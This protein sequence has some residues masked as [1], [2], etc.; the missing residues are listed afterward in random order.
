MT[1]RFWILLK[2]SI[3]FLWR[4]LAELGSFCQKHLAESDGI[5]QPNIVNEFC[6][7][8]DYTRMRSVY[9]TFAWFRGNKCS[10]MNTILWVFGR[11]QGSFLKL[12]ALIP[13][14]FN[15]RSSEILRKFYNS[16]T[17]FTTVA[18]AFTS[19]GGIKKRHVGVGKILLM[20]NWNFLRGQR[21]EW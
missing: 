2:R 9:W 18:W 6:V 12:K 13:N 20:K 15:T 14:P 11:G 1:N 8:M 3:R 16:S 5:A 21:F 7:Y 4:C 19:P 17:S 10:F